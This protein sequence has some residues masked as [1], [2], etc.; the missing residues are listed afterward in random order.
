ALAAGISLEARLASGDGGGI[1]NDL[2]H[3]CD[4]L[5]DA[6]LFADATGRVGFHG[7]ARVAADVGAVPA[8]VAALGPV[9]DA[10][11]TAGG[12]DGRDGADGGGAAP[13][14]SLVTGYEPLRG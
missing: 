5:P 11:R 3:V 2:R 1:A 6:A 9:G 10:A 12:H 14:R 7:W 8:G 13:A 4:A